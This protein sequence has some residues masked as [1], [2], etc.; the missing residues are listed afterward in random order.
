MN[1][2]SNGGLSMKDIHGRLGLSGEA[3]EIW[4][5]RNEGIDLIIPFL[6]ESPSDG[7]IGIS[8]VSTE[9]CIVQDGS[10]LCV[11]NANIDIMVFHRSNYNKEVINM[12]HKHNV[13]VSTSGWAELL[14]HKVNLFVDHSQVMDLE[15]LHGS[16]LRKYYAFVHD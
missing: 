12:A 3:Q 7:L 16:N 5:H 15:C 2:E 4:S 13:Y 1:Q 10:G 6:P 9:D 8:F 14:L 11:S